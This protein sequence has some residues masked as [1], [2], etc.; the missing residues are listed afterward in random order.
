VLEHSPSK[1]EA[2]FNHQYPPY[3][4]PQKTPWFTNVIP[5]TEKVEIEK[6]IVLISTGK[7]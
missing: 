6:I 4:T 7:K 3:P 2:E 1:Q 5:A